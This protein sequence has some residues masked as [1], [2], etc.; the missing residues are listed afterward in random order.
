[1]QKFAM[2]LIIE[3]LR[4][5]LLPMRLLQ[6]VLHL[7]LVLLVGGLVDL[8]ADRRNGWVVAQALVE[9][10]DE[11]KIAS[12]CQLQVFAT[13]MT[14]AG[15]GSLLDETSTPRIRCSRLKQCEPRRLDLLDEAAQRSM[16]S[17]ISLS[18]PNMLLAF[19]VGPHLWMRLASLVIFQPLSRQCFVIHCGGA[20]GAT[21]P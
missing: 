11:S 7:Y 15:L 19:A 12:L 17:A 21:W 5:L 3:I 13:R 16:L 20:S 9:Y 2:N 18:L 8:P 14:E 4:R 6:L 10:A 1:M